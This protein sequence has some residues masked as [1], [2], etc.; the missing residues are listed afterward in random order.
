MNFS[1]SLPLHVIYKR[2][3]T[4][5]KSLENLA[6]K[7]CK[8]YLGIVKLLSRNAKHTMDIIFFQPSCDWTSKFSSF[9]ILNY[10]CHTDFQ[11]IK[12]RLLLNITNFLSDPK[13]FTCLCMLLSFVLLI[14]LLTIIQK[15]I[16]P[17]P[18]ICLYIDIY[19]SANL[20]ALLPTN[21][22]EFN[23]KRFRDM[24]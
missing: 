17:F 8:L 6:D 10:H 21:F 16:F 3:W 5:T 18:S 1:L 23:L 22:Y 15:H 7:L 19:L 14:L 4:S 2:D 24:Q 13:S 20:S 12:K 11:K 9:I